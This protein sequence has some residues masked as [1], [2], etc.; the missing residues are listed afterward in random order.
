MRRRSLAPV[1]AFALAT[2][3]SGCAASARE[4]VLTQSINAE[5]DAVP[6]GLAVVESRSLFLNGK[7]VRVDEATLV[8]RDPRA[9]TIRK[10]RIWVG[11]QVAI[12]SGVWE[13]IALEPGSATKPARV[14]LRRV[15][16]RGPRGATSP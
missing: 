3:L 15:G 5:I 2:V 11:D 12:G 4:I 7:R 1:L 16:D 10:E 14:T 8:I 9:T 6:A 13:A